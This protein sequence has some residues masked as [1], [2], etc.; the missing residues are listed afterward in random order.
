MTPRLFI[1]MAAIVIAGG[2]ACGG[3]D[4]RIFYGGDELGYL[5]PCGCS[6]PQVGG[7]PR[8]ATLIDRL[9]KDAGATLLLERGNFIS[10]VNAQQRIKLE[11]ILLMLSEMGCAAATFGGNDLDLGMASLQAV[12]QSASFPLVSANAR[13]DLFVPFHI[14]TVNVKGSSF[15]IGVTAVAGE[16]EKS[17]F[18]AAGVSVD[19]PIPALND[20]LQTLRGQTDYRVVLANTTE[21]VAR[22]VA[23]ECLGVDLI[24]AS[25]GD[26]EPAAQPEKIGQTVIAFDG[27]RGKALGEVRLAVDDGRLVY[28]GHAVHSLGEDIVDSP[29]ITALMAYYEE[30]LQ[31]ESF[32]EKMDRLPAAGAAFTGP[33]RCIGCH[34]WQHETWK[35]TNHTRSLDALK[36]A[37]RSH[38]PE[39]VVCHVT[40][41]ETQGGFVSD[42]ATPDLGSVSCESCHGAAAE[43]VA[44]P[45]S[46]WRRPGEREC[47]ACH[48]PDHS[49]QFV[50]AEYLPKIDHRRP[51]PRGCT[52]YWFFG[53]AAV[54][55]FAVYTGIQKRVLR[56]KYRCT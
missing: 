8:R 48:T 56:R 31:A 55:G 53:S 37:F 26:D 13:S 50:F 49:P 1:G 12:R 51:P 16:Q 2:S 30:V 46:P 3:P 18:I 47:L 21:R 10:T 28:A 6:K 38:D 41:L 5:Q 15:R 40:A 33:S 45:E 29:A 39:C 24:I 23:E 4:V 42:A 35:M 14:T 7:F 34:R 52:G 17:K 32:V 22:T 36:S 27:R 44:S 20:V 11:V 25:R 43:H 19:E 9:R 54:V